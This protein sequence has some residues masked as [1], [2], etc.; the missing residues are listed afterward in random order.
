[1][2]AGLGEFRQTVL[3]FFLPLFLE[4]FQQALESELAVGG[5]GPAVGGWE[6][7]ILSRRHRGTEKKLC[8]LVPP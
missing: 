3:T 5:L 1:L 7:E 4:G 8:A 6:R 2:A